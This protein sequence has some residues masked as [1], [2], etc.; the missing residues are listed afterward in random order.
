MTEK[1]YTDLEKLQVL[2]SHWLEHNESHGR[3]YARW[4]EVARQAGRESAAD[5]IGRAVALLA[6]ADK[7]LEQALQAVGGPKQ[8]HSRHHHHD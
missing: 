4:S 5:H 6:E 3:E 2:I 1:Q 8:G 7:A